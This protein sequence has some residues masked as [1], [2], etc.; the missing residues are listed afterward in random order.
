MRRLV[1]LLLFPLVG[2]CAFL[3][4]IAQRPTVSLKRVDL[5]EVSFSGISVDFVLAVTNPNPIGLDLATL[6]YQI[7]VDNH[8]FVE[9]HTNSALHLPAQGVGEAH[10]PVGIKFLDFAQSLESLFGKKQVPY[11]LATRLGFGTPAGVL[12]VPLSTSGQLPVPQLPD[13]HFISAGLG[14]VSLTGADLNMIIGVR[15]TNNFAVPLGNLQYAIS[16]AGS[17]VISSGAPV[18]KLGPSASSPVNITAH[19]DYVGLGLGVVRAIQSGG[20]SIALDGNL[21]LGGY[22]MPLHLASHL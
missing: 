8:P 20:A 3:E 2:S 18:G 17:Q 4:S 9:G 7:T 12:E 6:A 13:V 5:Q 22:A 11:T 1:L 15:N 14:G 21:D 19:L 16:V 10:V